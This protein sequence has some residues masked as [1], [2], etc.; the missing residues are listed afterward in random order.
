MYAAI[1]IPLWCVSFIHKVALWLHKDRSTHYMYPTTTAETREM[2][3][4]FS[5][6]FVMWTY[7]FNNL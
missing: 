2:C 4:L 5:M 3:E 7:R 6:C 1:S